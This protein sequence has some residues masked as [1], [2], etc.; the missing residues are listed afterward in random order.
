MTKPFHL[1]GKKNQF[2][3]AD[4]GENRQEFMKR[5]YGMAQSDDAVKFLEDGV[6]T[7]RTSL[8]KDCVGRGNTF[9]APRIST[10][11]TNRDAVWSP[12]ELV[13]ID[14]TCGYQEFIMGYLLALRPKG[15]IPESWH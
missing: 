8:I 2:I 9:T 1:Y 4:T 12:P 15:S 5:I 10:G 3:G 7:I 14:H 13:G 11:A 6:F